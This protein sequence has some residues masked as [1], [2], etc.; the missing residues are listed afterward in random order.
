VN[1]SSILHKLY[2]SAFWLLASVASIGVATATIITAH[3]IVVVRN[4][5]ACLDEVSRRNGASI[6]DSGFIPDDRILIAAPT[7]HIDYDSGWAE[8]YSTRPWAF[9]I[10]L[11]LDDFGD[12]GDASLGRRG[13]GE[14]L[15]WWLVVSFIAALPLGVLVGVRRWVKWVLR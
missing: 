10:V 9:A 4:D 13:V 14:R 6:T 15:A 11:D 12:D 3:D 7:C 2:L 5:F 1:A 8:S